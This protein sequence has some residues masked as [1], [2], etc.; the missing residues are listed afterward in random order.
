V[1]AAL[2]FKDYHFA[3][4]ILERRFLN[5]QDSPP[6]LW[7]VLMECYRGLDEIDG[8]HGTLASMD[9]KNF[10]LF[11]ISQAKRIHD[12]NWTGLWSAQDSILQAELGAGADY[13]WTG[14]GNSGHYATLGGLITPG[15]DLSP[16][17][18]EQYFESLWRLGNWESIPEPVTKT[19]LYSAAHYQYTL[20]SGLRQIVDLTAITIDKV[21]FD[22][23]AIKPIPKSLIFFEIQEA[24]QVRCGF[25]DLEE[26]LSKWKTR[27]SSFSETMGFSD[28]EPIMSAR[29]IML[30][31][32]LNNPNLLNYQTGCRLAAVSN[33]ES[34]LDH[35]LRVKSLVHARKTCIQLRKLNPHLSMEQ[36]TKLQLKEFEI[37]WISGEKDIASK[38]LQQMISHRQP[39][40]DSYLNYLLLHKYASW[41]VEKM[42][43]GPQAVIDSYFIPALQNYSNSNVTEETTLYFDFACYLDELHDIKRADTTHER[44]I[45]HLKLRQDELNNL[46]SIQET[47]NPSNRTALHIRKL[48]KQIELE[49]HTLQSFETEKMEYAYRSCENFMQ[50]LLHSGYRNE[51]A[52][53][54]LIALWF[55]YANDSKMNN[56]VQ[57]M[58]FRVATNKFLHIL[59]QLTARLFAKDSHSCTEFRIILRDLVFSL[60]RDYPYHSIG[61]VLAAKNV[62]KEKN[63]VSSLSLDAIGD[64]LQKIKEAKE[65]HRIA[66]HMDTLF[67]GY[68][69]L[70]S[71]NPESV[72]DPNF[73]H[74]ISTNCKLLR[75]ATSAKIPVITANQTFQNPREYDNFIYVTHFENTYTIPGGLSHL[76]RYQCTKSGKMHWQ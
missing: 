17:R 51:H 74:K 21:D 42:L 4:Y 45:R 23:N 5:D 24:I 54:R 37:E 55:S 32:F 13:L 31:G 9:I 30:Q 44:S 66:Y 38:F 56:L 58:I 47:A 28:L 33:L 61:Y 69:S 6:E 26:C 15:A 11:S 34:L 12:Q 27:S 2:I 62:S 43:L 35:A 63:C 52:V 25:L 36:D 14:L 50:V 39:L 8:F 1:N 53:F 7:K 72:K 19:D 70:A 16:S 3:I 59:H 76:H 60:T 65:V 22:L 41:I 40:L 73:H 10:N 68:L 57:G 48:E 18:K 71:E 29:S 67:S 20:Y 46:K 49:N 75:I 64:F